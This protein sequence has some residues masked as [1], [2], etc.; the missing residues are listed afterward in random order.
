MEFAKKNI[1]SKKKRK[2]VWSKKKFGPKQKAWSRKGKKKVCSKTLKKNVWSKT[3]FVCVCVCVI[4]LN[5]TSAKNKRYFF[6]QLKF[7][8]KN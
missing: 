1:L 6:C 2:K 5:K 7:S 8:Y 4:S 3:V